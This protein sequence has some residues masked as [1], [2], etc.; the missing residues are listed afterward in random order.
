MA[1][2][3]DLPDLPRRACYRISPRLRRRPSLSPTARP[4]PVTRARTRAACSIWA[5]PT[6]RP[7]GDVAIDVP[8]D[9]GA[10]VPIRLPMASMRRADATT[11]STRAALRH[12]D[13][14]PGSRRHHVVLLVQGVDHHP[15]RS[16]EPEPGWRSPLQ[17]RV[18]QLHLARRMVLVRRRRRPVR[19]HVPGLGG[20][21]GE[22]DPGGRLRV[23]ELLRRLSSGRRHLR[24]R[25]QP[26]LCRLAVHRRFVRG[27][28]ARRTVLHDDRRCCSGTC[29]NGTCVVAL[30]GVCVS[31]AG[32]SQG[33]CRDG[34]CQCAVN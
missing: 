10:C 24:R 8:L 21:P 5:A 2:T 28:R 31:Q 6:I 30:G 26:V 34:R 19:R 32:C 16:G 9:R 20:Q 33:E 22:S 12:P 11:P 17:A 25:H 18:E 13:D 1:C 4:M 29:Q 3:P 27:L 7:G 23:G 14:R 15:P